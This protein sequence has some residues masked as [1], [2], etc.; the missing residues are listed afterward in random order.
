MLVA[1]VFK[2]PADRNLAIRERIGNLEDLMK[3]GEDRLQKQC[4][5]YQAEIDRLKSQRP[6]QRQVI[7][8]KS[9]KGGKPEQR[10]T[11]IRGGSGRAGGLDSQKAGFWEQQQVAKP[12]GQ[13]AAL[14]ATS[15]GACVL[16]GGFALSFPFSHSIS[17]CFCS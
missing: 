8:N 3:E 6:T 14:D 2:K 13:L 4:A 17:C 5:H 12:E 11:A 10:P 9:V 7:R 16:F 15:E 1:L